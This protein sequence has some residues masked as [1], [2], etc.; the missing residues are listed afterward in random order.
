MA[1]LWSDLP[2]MVKKI[3]SS[4]RRERVSAEALCFRSSVISLH[5]GKM[6]KKSDIS[7]KL[8][9]AHHESQKS[10]SDL[11]IKVS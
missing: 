4:E 9:K 11:E 5:L 2:G 1:F 8:V 7:L 3:Q 10:R 6:K